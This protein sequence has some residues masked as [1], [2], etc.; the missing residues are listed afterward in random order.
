[1]PV[2][3]NNWHVKLNGQVSLMLTGTQPSTPA[4]RPY[5]VSIDLMRGLVMVLMAL[6][7]VRWFFTDAD[8]S[9]T[10]L[11]HTT[12]PIFLTRW[13]THLCAPAFV[14]L[15]G[16]SAF[17]SAQQGLTKSQ[18]GARLFTRGLW[19][20]LLE[21][22]AVNL[23]WTF[24]LDYRQWGVGVLWALG[25]SMVALSVLIHLP[26]RAI[27][28]VGI[29]M[30]LSHNLMDGIQIEDFLNPDGTLG[31]QGWLL[32]IL[33]IPHGAISYPLVPWIGVMTAGYAFGPIML[34]EREQRKQLMLRWG[35]T[36]V[37]AF[38][39]LRGW[40][41]YGDPEPWH[42][43]ERATFTLL[44]FLNTTKYPPSLLYLLMTLGPMLLLLSAFEREHARTGVISLYLVTFGRVPLFF[45]LLHLYAIH[46]LV[47]V[48]AIA[49]H[50]DFSQFLTSS[51]SFPSWWGF[52][53]PIVYLIFAGVIFLLYPACRWF[54]KFK[55]RHRGAW[56]T[57]YI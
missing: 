15:S 36:L 38:I 2:D 3:R 14:F 52:S 35:W 19:L 27:V 18:L 28:F 13:I 23:A 57:P 10:D 12:P 42:W 20:A 47:I 54:A 1:M 53:L 49:M 37:T 46:A 5:I 34:M 33:H 31:W 44:S 11:E 50:Q 24:N 26:M 22:T 16:T 41:G 4:P 45:Y 48:F 9:P 21:A 7:H 56:W 25:W 6:D 30:I 51:S 32:S 55:S 43:Q 39:A 40:N 17:L 29:G 8:F